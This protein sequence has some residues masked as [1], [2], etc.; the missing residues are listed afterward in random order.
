[1]ITAPDL[2]RILEEDEPAMPRETYT[3]VVTRPAGV[4]VNAMK[5]YIQD[6]V[7]GWKGAFAPE[8]P[9]FYLDRDIVVRRRSNEVIIYEA[10]KAGN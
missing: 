5:R 1:M 4:S 2:A 8:D 10:E 7:A 6:A 3:I 9:L